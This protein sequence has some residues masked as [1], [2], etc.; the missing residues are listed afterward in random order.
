VKTLIQV[1]AGVM[2]KS[3]YRCLLAIWL[4]FFGSELLPVVAAEPAGLGWQSV[5]DGKSLGAWKSTD[6]GGGGD[7]RVEEGLLIVDQGEELS[8][9]R[10]TGAFPKANYEL[11]LEAMRRGGLDFFCGLT[12][13]A[14]ESC[15]TFVVGGWSGATVGISSIDSKDASKNETTLTRNFEDNRWYKIRLRVE[16]GRIQAWIDEERVVNLSTTG[17]VLGMRPGEIEL[18]VPLGI[19]TFR[20][21]AAYKGVRYRL[22]EG[23]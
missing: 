21:P 5:F 8:G 2:Q 17:K 7:V 20:T 13:P 11:E 4:S 22:L 1:K 12:F 6:Y 10:W 18:S 16:S 9:V 15:L 3:V 19:S 14:G 23:K